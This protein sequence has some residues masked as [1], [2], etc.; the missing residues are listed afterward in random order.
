METKVQTAYGEM[1]VA[2]LVKY[3]EMWKAMA[4][5]HNDYKKVYNQTEQGREKNR[6]RSKVYYE[7]HR[8][9]VL[10]KRRSKRDQAASVPMFLD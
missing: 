6:E 5:K 1:T 9:Q 10:E 8:D 7:R 3:T 2:E 4:A